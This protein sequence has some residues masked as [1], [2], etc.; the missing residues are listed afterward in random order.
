MS[1]KIEFDS[2]YQMI[3]FC[4]VVA[5]DPFT[6]DDDDTVAQSTDDD[7][8]PAHPSD[9]DVP[10]GTPVDYTKLSPGDRVRWEGRTIWANGTVD[11]IQVLDNGDV[12]VRIQRDDNGSTFKITFNDEPT[13]GTMY[14]LWL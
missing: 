7:T 8:V 1:V 6:A 11:D 9:T 10:R 4:G 12:I 3:H 13:F 14:R 2:V 5:G